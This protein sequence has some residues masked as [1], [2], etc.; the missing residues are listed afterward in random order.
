MKYGHLPASEQVL[1]YALQTKLQD[2]LKSSWE[3]DNCEHGG[4]VRSTVSKCHSRN[5]EGGAAGR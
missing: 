3:N 1:L 5:F 4:E 2:L